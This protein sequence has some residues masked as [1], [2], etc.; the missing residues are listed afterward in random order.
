M[1][2]YLKFGL[3][4]LLA[5]STVFAA[6]PLSVV[7]VALGPNEI[8][9]GDSV[10]IVEVLSDSPTLEVG[11][12]VI[13]RGRYTLVSRARAKVSLSQTRTESRAMVPILPG[14]GIEVSRGS[15]E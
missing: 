12:R 13:V 11:S 2:T 14:S 7:R 4:V 1:K 3:L 6:R 9:E 8:P 10:T 5:V 15:G